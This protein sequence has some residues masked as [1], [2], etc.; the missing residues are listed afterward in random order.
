MN[1]KTRPRRVAELVK[2]RIAQ[3]LIKGL[4]DPRIG[5]VSVMGV[6]MSSDLRYANVHVSLY[7]SETERKASMAGLKHSTGW[8]RREVGRALKIRCVPE[9]RF[10]EDTTLDRVYKLEEV[11]EQIHHEEKKD[12]NDEE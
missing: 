10:F 11:F 3:L 4:K 2:E 12:E 9:I 6:Q 1:S 8:I 5:F 7:G